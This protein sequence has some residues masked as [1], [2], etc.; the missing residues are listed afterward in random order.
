[1]NR[2]GSRF[3]AEVYWSDFRNS[4]ILA[5]GSILETRHREPYTGSVLGSGLRHGTRVPDFSRANVCFVRGHLTREKLKVRC[6]TVGDP[7]I[8]VS[9]LIPASPVRYK[10]GVIF[11]FNDSN[12]K[13]FEQSMTR[14]DLLIIDPEQD[15]TSVAPLVSSCARIVS[16]SLHGLILADSYGI[17][18]RWLRM[19]G[20][21]EPDFKYHDYFSSVNRTGDA[22]ASFSLDEL[23][24]LL[25]GDIPYWK[26]VEQNMDDLEKELDAYFRNLPT[27]LP[28]IR[29]KQAGAKADGRF[30]EWLLAKKLI[31]GDRTRTIYNTMIRVISALIPGRH[32]RKDF[33]ES[34]LVRQANRER[35]DGCN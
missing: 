31:R 28:L 32:R 23:D 26:F 3:G 8:L 2:V 11:H 4:E 21:A 24:Q 20:N 19:S 9:R 12:R 16:S 35:G 10:I 1:M 18:N 22:A 15:V 13:S 34:H 7:G 17:P 33:R 5:A 30:R 29:K 14:D 25:P 27:R 6:N